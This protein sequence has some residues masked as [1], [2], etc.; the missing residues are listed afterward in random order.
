M[1]QKREDNVGEEDELEVTLKRTM[2]T[3]H[4]ARRYKNKHTACREELFP[5]GRIQNNELRQRRLWF[6][7]L[8]SPIVH[9][10]LNPNTLI[11]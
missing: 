7:V 3:W 11:T 6:R 1:M 9:M 10:L 4:S 8:M 2:Q 5:V